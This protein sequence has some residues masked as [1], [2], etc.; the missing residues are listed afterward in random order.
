MMLASSM[1]PTGAITST[2]TSAE[3][4]YVAVPVFAFINL[5]LL[6]LFHEFL[7]AG[8]PVIA[9]FTE[10]KLPGRNVVPSHW[11]PSTC[12]QI[13][14]KKSFSSL[15]KILCKSVNLLGLQWPTSTESSLLHYLYHC[16]CKY[17]CIKN[18]CINTLNS[19]FA[20]R[21]IVFEAFS[22]QKSFWIEK[23]SNI[24]LDFWKYF[25]DLGFF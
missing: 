5:F 8:V 13:F 19:T 4:S 24:S 18:A 2:L 3:I 6:Y 20:Q 9:M 22:W 14:H 23:D 25:I 16:T 11:S 21:D 15:S 7:N 12:A 10:G 17:M 1:M